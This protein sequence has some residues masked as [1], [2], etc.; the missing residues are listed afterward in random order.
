MPVAYSAWLRPADAWK[1]K[2]WI[3]PPFLAGKIRESGSV[4]ETR[5]GAAPVPAARAAA[6]RWRAAAALLRAAATLA[7]RS[8][9]TGF[10]PA[11]F[12]P[13]SIRAW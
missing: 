8:A 11:H 2:P 13:A 1:L 12:F 10:L 4:A 7:L 3:Q 6:S 5:T 9:G